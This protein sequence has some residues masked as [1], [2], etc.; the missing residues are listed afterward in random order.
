MTPTAPA[1]PL[2]PFQ[3]F[4]FSASSPSVLRSPSS[5]LRLP[6]SVLRPP[7][8]ILRFPALSFRLCCFV[9][10]LLI[11]CAF[12]VSVFQL[13]SIFFPSSV[14]RL[15][16]SAFQFSAS[17]FPFHTPSAAVCS[18]RRKLLKC[19]PARLLASNTESFGTSR[20]SKWLG[21]HSWSVGTSK[22]YPARPL[23]QPSHQNHS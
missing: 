21:I 5:V 6:S 19:I 20:L 7:S 2:S 11:H 4:S 15:P 10:L 23:P 16:I 13:F 14:F 3:P 22:T 8:S 17:T 12:S 1:H 9:T 18:I